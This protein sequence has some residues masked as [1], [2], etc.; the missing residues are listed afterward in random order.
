MTLMQ[1]FRD[2][3]GPPKIRWHKRINWP[4]FWLGQFWWLM[5]TAHFGWNMTPQSDAELLCDGLVILIT[6]LAV[7]PVN[8]TDKP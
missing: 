3:V 6:A 5:E 1:T 8:G 2:G 7:R 4:V